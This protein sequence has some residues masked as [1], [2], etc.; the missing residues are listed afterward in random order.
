M[1]LLWFKFT[2][3]SVSR[4]IFTLCSC[5]WNKHHLIGQKTGCTSLREFV[6]TRTRSTRHRKRPKTHNTWFTLSIC[7]L[8]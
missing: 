5:S 2:V 4:W 3:T 7:S 6:C 8:K 1:R